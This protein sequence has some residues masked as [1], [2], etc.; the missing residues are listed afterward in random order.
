MDQC[1]LHAL[2]VLIFADG[3]SVVIN[4]KQNRVLQKLANVK[5]GTALVSY[6]AATKQLFLSDAKNLVHLYK[7]DNT[8]SD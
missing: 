6:I 5:P 4:K 7:L 8:V 1:V 3:T 2:A